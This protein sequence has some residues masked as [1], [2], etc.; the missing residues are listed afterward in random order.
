MAKTP[1]ARI[2][3]YPEEENLQFTSGKITTQQV[4]IP[5]GMQ[6]LRVVQHGDQTKLV[7]ICNPIMGAIPF[8][9]YIVPADVE[10]DFALKFCTYID[11]FVSNDESYHVFVK[12]VKLEVSN[13]A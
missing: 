6:A 13:G 11:T 5:R 2:R 9:I 12:E 7:C 4:K 10:I 1:G 3:E 8:T